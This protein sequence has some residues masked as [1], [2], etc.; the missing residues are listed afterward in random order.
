V[1]LGWQSFSSTAADVWMD[2][3]ALSTTGRIGCN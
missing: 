2:D 1:M 3:V